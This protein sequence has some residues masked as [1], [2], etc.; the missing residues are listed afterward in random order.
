MSKELT[1]FEKCN[2]IKRTLLR[3]AAESTMYGNMVS[4]FFAINYITCYLLVRL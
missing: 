1:T 3:A 4:G 2:A